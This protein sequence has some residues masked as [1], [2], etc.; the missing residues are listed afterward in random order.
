MSRISRRTFLKTGGGVAAGVSAGVI[1]IHAHAAAHEQGRAT[2]AYPRKIVGLAKSM[3]LNTAV[4]FSFPD[5]SSPCAMIKMGKPVPGGVGPDQDIVAY[6]TMCP[7]MG[8]PVSYDQ[9][10]RTFRCPCHYSTFDAEMT[11]QMV[12]GQATEN[13][14]KIVLEYNAKDDSVT[15]VAVDGLIYGRQA[16]VL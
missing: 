14:P 1:P 4:A 10:T 8:C 13:L 7:H 9:S 15:A 2:L 3:P 16:N 6:S 11:G 12:C 5:E